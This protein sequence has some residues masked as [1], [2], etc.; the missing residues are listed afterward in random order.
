MRLWGGRFA[1]ETD[2]RAAAF[3]R[4]IEVDRAL[5]LDD[6]RGSV[7]HVRGLGRAGLLDD[8]EVA[9]LTAGLGALRAEVEAGTL[10]WDLALEDVHMNLEAALAARIGPLAGK[11]HTGRSRN[12]QVATDLRLWSRRTIDGLDDAVLGME[13]ALVALGEREGDAIIPGLTHIQPAQPILFAHHLLAYVEMFERDRGRLADCRRRANVSPLGSGALAGAGYP[14]DR[15]STAW[16]LGFDGATA[17]SLDSVSDRDFVAEL[18]FSVALGMVHL[19][20]LAEEITWW[21]NPRFGFVR[22]SDAFTT[23]SS[24][25]PNKKNPDPAELVRG[26]AARVVGSLAGFL[27]LLK[28]LPL[29]YQRDLQEDKPPLFEACA[30]FGASLDVMAGMV[31]TMAVDRDAMR[32]AASDGFTTAT[33]VA[34]A[35]V[36]RGVAFREAHHVVGRLVAAAEAGSLALTELGDGVIVAALAESRD[37]A[38]I[39]LAG[40]PELPVALREAATLDAALASCDVIGGTAP[41]RVAAA[42][43]AARARLDGVGG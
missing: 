18:L 39:E 13:R 15:E 12:D 16:E 7:A 21:S 42:L 6:L 14:L 9:A 25:M 17:N 34:D 4:S 27:A 26:R 38:A 23:G 35:L 24:M 33:A 1:G 10:A 37:S 3:T 36:R 11:L 41:R 20:R 28:G 43:A 8:A 32:R 40:D 22:A 2:P 31:E 29:A 5:A 30:A 19:S